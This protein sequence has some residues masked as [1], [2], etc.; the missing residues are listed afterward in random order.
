MPNLSK[1][2]TCDRLFQLMA[3][4]VYSGCLAIVCGRSLDKVDIEYLSES[5]QKHFHAVELVEA[6]VVSTNDELWGSENLLFVLG[7]DQESSRSPQ[8]YAIRTALDV[9]RNKGLCSIL[10]HDEN[11]FSKHYQDAASPFYLFCDSVKLRNITD[12]RV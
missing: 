11:G 4:G 2:V 9:R 8:S 7:L 6:Q 10:F 5:A 3:D 1:I 12:F